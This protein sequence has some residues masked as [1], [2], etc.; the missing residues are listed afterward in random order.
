MISY[1][2]MSVEDTQANS[3]VKEEEEPCMW[4][5]DDRKL[6]ET[7]ECAGMEERHANG[8]EMASCGNCKGSAHEIVKDLVHKHFW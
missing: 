7:R 2:T 5:V 8:H 6:C 4:P 3:P 1:A